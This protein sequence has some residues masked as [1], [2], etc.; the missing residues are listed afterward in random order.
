MLFN[1]WGR[2]CE[3]ETFGHV[4]PFIAILAGIV[5]CIA[6]HL[7]FAFQNPDFSGSFK[8]F[9]WYFV[10]FH[11]RDFVVFPWNG[12][13]NT[14]QLGRVY[15]PRAVFILLPADFSRFQRSGYGG[16]CNP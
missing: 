6:Q 2:R 16:G 5:Q 12:W 9:R 8:C 7:N 14:V 4:A 10:L 11:E 3:R 15:L 1:L 13:K